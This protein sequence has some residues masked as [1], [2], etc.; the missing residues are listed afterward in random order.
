MPAPVRA[1]VHPQA[2]V[3]S[4]DDTWTQ[5]P[6]ATVPAAIS[7]AN[8]LLAFPRHAIRRSSTTDGRAERPMPRA[9]CEVHAPFAPPWQTD[10]PG[11]AHAELA[12]RG[13]D[14]QPGLLPL[15]SIPGNR[16]V[17]A[18][19]G[20]GQ[21]FVVQPQKSPAGLHNAERED[22]LVFVALLRCQSNAFFLR[23]A[24]PIQRTS[25]VNRKTGFAVR[26]RSEQHAMSIWA[27]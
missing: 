15:L 1:V 13:F 25:A 21:P 27:G 7:N 14:N 6:I 24:H 10:H 8:P 18:T 17:D 9:G 22:A 12:R 20:L 16:G 3:R 11:K 23:P 4:P 26:L 5:H 2:P 19:T